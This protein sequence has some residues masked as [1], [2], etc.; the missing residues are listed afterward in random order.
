MACVDSNIII[1]FL[2]N[3]EPGINIIKKLS[4]KDQELVTTSINSF[5]ILKGIKDVSREKQERIKSLLSKFKIL[6][7]DSE[8]SEKA[9]E[10]FESLKKEG[11]SLD[12]ADIRI[13]S[14]AIKNKEIN[15]TQKTIF[16]IMWKA[17][18]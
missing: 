7:F 6:N 2:R 1:D 10:I 17:S 5:E 13:A 14:I 3:K 8:S 4:Q 18:K 16:D 11:Q 9:A 15:K 12:L